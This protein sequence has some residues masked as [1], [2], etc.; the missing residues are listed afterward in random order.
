MRAGGVLVGPHTGLTGGVWVYTGRKVRE[1]LC[2]VAHLEM[3]AA[4]E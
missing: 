3:W 4:C 2:R 1:G